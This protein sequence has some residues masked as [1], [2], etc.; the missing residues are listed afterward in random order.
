MLLG[1][2][3][4]FMTQVMKLA[5]VATTRQVVKI[6]TTVLCCNIKRL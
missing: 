1:Y 4:N 6:N 5:N 2:H 3:C